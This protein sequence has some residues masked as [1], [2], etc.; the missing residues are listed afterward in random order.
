M[1]KDCICEVCEKSYKFRASKNRPNS[2][3]CSNVC[4]NQ[5]VGTWVKG[6]PLGFK[7]ATATEEEKLKRMED[8]FE[9]MVIRQK[10]CWGWKGITHHS[11]GYG[12]LNFKSKNTTIAA[13]RASWMIYRGSIPDGL[14]VLHKCDNP[15]CTNPDHLFI[16]TNFENVRDMVYKNR[17]AKGSYAGTSKLNEEQVLEI[18][19]QLS[20]GIDKKTIAAEF[21]V[22]KECVYHIQIGKTWKHIQ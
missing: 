7:W 17:Q 21:G 11:R 6:N 16:G 4:K 1:L 20:G 14:H 3:F 10:G 18:K 9:R 22:T 8:S 19:S 5:R 13:H 2:R 15:S 12:R